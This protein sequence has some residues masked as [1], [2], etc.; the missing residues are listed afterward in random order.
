[1]A[2][3]L[4][5]YTGDGSTTTYTIGFNYRS[6]D[7][8][9]VTLDGVTKTI[10]TDYTFPSSSQITFGTAPGSNVAIQ[11]T[12]STSQSTR[13]VDYAAGSVFKESDLDTDSTQGFNMAQEAIDIAN[14]AMQRTLTNVFDADN[15]KIVNVATPTAATDA[16]NKAYVDT[17]AD[18]AANSATASANS[19]TASAN[20]ATQ[21]A[22]SATASAASA[23]AS[24]ASESNASTSE[25]NSATSATQSANSAT[26]SANSASAAS[27]SESNAASSASTASTQAANS[28]TSATNSANSATAS[29]NSATAAA[30]SASTASTQ[31]ALATTNGA[32]QVALATTQANNAATSATAAANSATAASN[33]QVAAAA[34]AASAA[35]TYDLFDD[36][37]LGSFTSNPTVDNDG[38]ALVSGSLYFNSS[39]NEMRVFDGGNWIAASSAGTASLLEYKYT[40]TAGQTTFSGSDDASNTLSYTLDNLIVTLNGVVLENGT[41]YTATSGTSIV[42]ASG[43]AVSDELNV[44]AFKSF[45]TADMVSKTNGG[46]FAG[47]VTFDAGANFGDNDKAQF[48]AGNDLQIYHD[49]SNSYVKDAGTGDLL[50]QG[51]QIKLQDASGN[52][53]LRG[54]TGGAVYLHHAGNTKFETTSSGV[55]VTGQVIANKGSTG[56]LAT[57][58]DG[59]ATNFTMK[60][61]GNSVGTFGTEAG[62]TQL[63]FMVAN[64]EAARFD[65]NRNLLVGKNSSNIGTAGSEVTPTYISATR[66]NNSPLF[67]NRTNSDGSI[68]TFR[69][70]NSTIG[71]I[72]VDGGDNLFI[73]GQTGNTGGL[74]FNDAAI[75]PAYQG[76]ERDN[77]YDL[78]KS[79]ARFQNGWFSN[80]LYTHYLRGQND[81][82]TGI[83]V[84]D[85][86][87]ANT[88][89]FITGGSERMRIDGS[90]QSYFFGAPQQSGQ[91]NFYSAYEWAISVRRPS[92]GS[93][94]MIRFENGTSYVG[95]ITTSTTATQYNTSSDY[96]LKENVTGIANATD[97]LKQLNPVRF[98]FIADADTT[99]DGFLAHEVS[100]IVPEAISGEKDAMKDEQY[101]VTPAVLD[102]DGNEVTP[103]EIGTRNVPD[104]QGIDQSKL[105]PLLCATLK[106]SIAKIET[107]ETEMTTLKE[108][109]NAL[110]NTQ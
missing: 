1:M 53:Y 38:D 104:Y 7:D 89:T 30:G 105:V 98:N 110:E 74:Y 44:I 9:V 77:Y 31:A 66:A 12:R 68:I 101:E 41:D 16:A 57:F 47:A 59:V 61:D 26:A 36:R 43:A 96:R 82:D 97:R 6:T 75:S 99:V 10:T 42:L 95:G 49:S 15:V 21:S 78:G 3:A 108:R 35:S 32:A 22:N 17:G 25:T 34:S 88:L 60:T 14:N 87:T 52:D 102:D 64:T 20:S 65:Q 28:A 27:T 33:S 24:A 56:T 92:S 23:T 81:T 54:F 18:N 8:V 55:S 29:A 19:A 79:A 90:G 69:K 13:L 71:L 85:T 63:A 46:T 45:T 106:E 48:G 50:V 67:L 39:A 109:V 5:K 2:Y 103:A 70:D 58:T 51:T 83:N 100:D 107:L 80:V 11:F 76:V 40:A 72:G 62:S 86:G 94:G 73:T 84:G 91:A 37:F 93:A 4:T